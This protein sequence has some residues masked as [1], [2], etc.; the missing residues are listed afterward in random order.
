M[1][2]GEFLNICYKDEFMVQDSD[3]A[4]G[5]MFKDGLKKC[6]SNYE[7]QKFWLDQDQHEI[8]ILLAD[9]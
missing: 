9:V 3:C 6:F 2:V 5:Y 7:I 4:I 1:T 8:C